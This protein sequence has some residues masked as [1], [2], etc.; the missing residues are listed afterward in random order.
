MRVR[1]NLCSMSTTPRRRYAPRVPPHE[2]REQILDAALLVIVED[3][4]GALSMEELARRLDVTRPVLY[5][6]FANMDE[7]QRELLVREEVRALGQVAAA[8][9]T[10]E[11]D[12][13]PDAVLVEGVRMILAAVQE[14]PL[15]WRFVLFPPDGT[16]PALRAHQERMR[17]GVLEQV[18]R[19][20]EWGVPRRGGPRG[21]DTELLA[22][23]V[24]VLAEESARLVL[25]RPGDFPPERLTGFART[26]LAALQRDG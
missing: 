25:V 23:V 24:I 15:T 26:M 9:P 4:F 1:L 12:P 19:L 8:M 20:M 17:Q 18:E 7:V 11:G 16:P 10:L 14:S 5:S 22:R 6:V 3:G 2:R 21:V 13:D